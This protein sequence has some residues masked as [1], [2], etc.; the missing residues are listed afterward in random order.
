MAVLAFYDY[1]YTFDDMLVEPEPGPSAPPFEEESH[2]H[3]SELTG[4][5][6]SAPPL[7][8]SEAAYYADTYPSAP[9]HD[10]Q[11]GSDSELS[12]VDGH[13]AITIPPRDD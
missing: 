4:L 7:T 1:P 13:T 8:E 9:A 6:P 12:A 11:Y 2:H 3:P 5:A 10:W